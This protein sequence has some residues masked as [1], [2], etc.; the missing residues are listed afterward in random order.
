MAASTTWGYYTL[1]SSILNSIGRV[2]SCQT[3][4]LPEIDTGFIALYG[5]HR[6]NI[7][8]NNVKWPLEQHYH[9]GI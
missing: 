3:E 1:L 8:I 9:L 4:V 6:I 5:S 7:V 2:H